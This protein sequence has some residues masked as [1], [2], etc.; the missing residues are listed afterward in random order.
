[1]HSSGRKRER[2]GGNVIGDTDM[3]K[4]KKKEWKGLSSVTK[5]GRKFP[6]EIFGK[7][8]ASAAVQ[9]VIHSWTWLKDESFYYHKFFFCLSQCHMAQNQ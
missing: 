8:G 3:L 1:M 4:K 7:M 5:A 2:K 9:Q 6:N